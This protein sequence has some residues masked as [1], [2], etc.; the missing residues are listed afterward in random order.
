MF[1]FWPQMTPTPNLQNKKSLSGSKLQF[2]LSQALI[3]QL[4][5]EI[6]ENKPKPKLAPKTGSRIKSE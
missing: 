4:C 3:G 1:G 5:N 2:E 6:C